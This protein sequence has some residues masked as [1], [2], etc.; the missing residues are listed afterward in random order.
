MAISAD[1]SNRDVFIGGQAET[2]TDKPT[3]ANDEI[4]KDA[5]LTM[6]VA[7]LKNQDP[8]NPMEGTDFTAQLAQFSSLEQQINTNTNLSSILGALQASSDETNLFNYIGRNITSE[9]NPVTVEGGDVVSGGTF[10]LGETATIDVV[11]YNN[12]GNPVRVL[13]SGSET[14]KKGSYNI[15][16]DGKDENG[17]SVLNGEYTYDV[18]AKNLDGEYI[19]VTTKSSGLVSGLTTS[20]GKTYLVVDGDRVDPDSVEAISM[21]ED[22]EESEDTENSEDTEGAEG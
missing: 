19:E 8:L 7:Q 6:M 17:Y 14:L 4:G 3:D 15:E 20:G 2:V 21:V 1:Y 5:F 11:V 12:E 9:G 13:S 18:I 10:N 16:W 22:A